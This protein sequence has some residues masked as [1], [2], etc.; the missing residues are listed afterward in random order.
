MGVHDSGVCTICAVH[1]D[2]SQIPKV[3]NL[4]PKTTVCFEE[5][6]V[7]ISRNYEAARNGRH[8]DRLIRIWRTKERVR[9][10]D[11]C[12]IDGMEH[13]II[14]VQYTVDSDGILVTDLTLEE[15]DGH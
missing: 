1:W 9:T 8:A 15:N 2:D 12:I 3:R 13:H 11:V 4:D 10:N 7:G 6:T 14:Q 5:R